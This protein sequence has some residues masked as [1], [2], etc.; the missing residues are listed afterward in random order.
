[1]DVE[2]DYEKVSMVEFMLVV[3]DD[4]DVDMFDVGMLYFELFMEVE[5]L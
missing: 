5:M 2:D 1:M 4:V 3:D